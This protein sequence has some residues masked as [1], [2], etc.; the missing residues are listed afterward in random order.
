MGLNRPKTTVLVENLFKF[1]SWRRRNPC[2]K[3]QEGPY[4]YENLTCYKELKTFTAN[5]GEESVMQ[6]HL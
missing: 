3:S 4:Q 2:S 1:D 5:R 6:M